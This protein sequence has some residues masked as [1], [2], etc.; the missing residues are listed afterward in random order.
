[1][2]DKSQCE[3]YHARKRAKERYNLDLS[4]SDIKMIISDIQ[5]HTAIFV[6]KQS[7][8]VSVWKISIKGNTY[9][10]V[11]DKM[12][13]QIITFLPQEALI[14]AEKD[15][16]EDLR[17]RENIKKSLHKNIEIPEHWKL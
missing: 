7:C 9:P 1:M 4:T 16:Q 10:V 3:F 6:N 2:L 13:H 14:D 15:R 12:R 5:N 17:R 11:Y 8:R